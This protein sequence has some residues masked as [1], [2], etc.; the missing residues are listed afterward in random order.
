[1]NDHIAKPIDIQKLTHFCRNR[2]KKVDIIAAGRR[3]NGRDT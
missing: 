3:C 1:M 2:Y